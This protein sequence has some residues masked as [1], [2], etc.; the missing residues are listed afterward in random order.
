MKTLEKRSSSAGRNSNRKR[1]RLFE[2]LE[3][4]RLLVGGAGLPADM[5]AD[6]Y[7]F[8][9][10]HSGSNSEIWDMQVGGQTITAAGYG[11]VAREKLSL[12]KGQSY[13]INVSHLGTNRTDG[14][15]NPDPD[16]DYRAW[17]DNSANPTWTSGSGTPSGTDF[18]VEDPSGLLQRRFFGSGTNHATGT[19]TLHVPLI[20]LD[21]D[22]DNSG[23]IDGTASE[24]HLE[25]SNRDGVFVQVLVGDSDNDGVLDNM[26]F[27]GVTGA[28]FT[29]IQIKMSANVGVA[30][31]TTSLTFDFDDAGMGQ[32]GAY[33]L[34]KKDAPQGRS[35]AD[36]VASGTQISAGDIGLAPGG[37]VTLYLEAVSATSRRTNFDP[38]EVTAS[39]S[40]GSWTGSLVDKVHAVGVD[41]DIDA[42]TIS[43]NAVSGELAES[44]EQTDGAFVLV[45]NDDDDYDANNTADAS[46]TGAIVGENDL[47]PIV[48]KDQPRGGDYT[49]SIPQHLRVWR[50]ADRTDQILSSTSI[51]AATQTELYVEG[52]AEATDEIQLNWS[53]GSASF[54]NTDRI[55]V[56]AF[57]LSGP[58][59]VPGNSIYTYMVS[60]VQ[61]GSW[62]N[63]AGGSVQVSSA[64][65]AD[66]KWANTPAVGNVVY[67]PTSEYSWG[68]DVNVVA[69]NFAPGSTVTYT[70]GN[71]VQS[72]GPGG[73]LIKSAAQPNAMRAD[74]GVSS[75]VG[76]TVNGSQ[77]GRK[78]IEVGV[79]H[80]AR[81]VK[82]HAVAINQ[83]Q[84]IRRISNLE[85]S[86]WY[87]DL[88]QVSAAPWVD[89]NDNHVLDI[90]TDTQIVDGN[91]FATGL[92]ATGDTPQVKA[93][94]TFN[95]GGA[96]T[97]FE[98]LMEHRNFV[99]VRAK[100]PNINGSADVLTQLAAW[101]WS[102]DGSGS[103]DATLA[104]TPTGQGVQGTQVQFVTDGRRVPSVSGNMPQLLQNQTWTTQ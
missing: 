103:V 28:A 73:L 22:S 53:K 56:T 24:D 17:V 36:L 59:N 12:E 21:V 92:F 63:A 35:A 88:F 39:I 48:L 10:D 93:S 47:L 65:S 85:N 90:T 51:S 45:N 96:V 4:R 25:I 46:Q 78:F 68:L 86:Q 79:T 37:T 33:R 98:I 64:T 2:R 69:I 99:A 72:A 26:D 11:D 62:G 42:K 3:D 7:A 19:A 87:N 16:Y 44:K 60:G 104:Y 32:T 70:S 58:L 67:A 38:I 34:W 61:T 27:N 81:F 43:Q 91:S 6:P 23:A 71:P 5:V 54:Q 97:N 101:E 8:V 94:D 31:G 18:F 29:P 57:S 95:F 82:K 102:F 89:G 74:L 41:F 84:T 1:R 40:G 49:L 77:R 20:D 30:G 52:I 80:Q 75:V 13:S 100:G 9:G 15:G 76:P 14:N 55:K 83:G 66:V 50:N